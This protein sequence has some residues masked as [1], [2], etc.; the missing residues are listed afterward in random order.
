MSNFGKYF[1]LNAKWKDGPYRIVK[2]Y[3]SVNIAIENTKGVSKIMHHNNLKLVGVDILQ[4]L[5]PSYGIVIQQPGSVEPESQGPVRCAL[6]CKPIW[7]LTVTERGHYAD[8]E[9]SREDKIFIVEKWYETRSL[10]FIR[11]AFQQRDARYHGKNLPSRT[12]IERVVKHFQR[13]GTVADLRNT[14]LAQRGRDFSPEKVRLAKKFYARRQKAS[15][16]RASHST[17]VKWYFVAKI[18]KKVLKKKSFKSAKTEKLTASQKLRRVTLCKKLINLP[19]LT[20]MLK[21]VWFT[22]ESWF[23]SDGIAQNNKA[24]YWALSKD[25]VKPTI[26]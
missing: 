15:L 4:D 19:R 11:R 1:K 24:F 12:S 3:G 23:F 10:A 26:F 7:K 18:L 13:S 8:S 9:D 17:N 25:A 2:K 6:F 22:D 16:R 14:Y 5:W 20:N 21:N